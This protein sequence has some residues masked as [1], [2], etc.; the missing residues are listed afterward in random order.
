MKAIHPSVECA[1]ESQERLKSRVKRCCVGSSGE[2]LPWYSP[3]V[4]ANINPN[5]NVRIKAPKEGI[6][7]AFLGSRGYPTLWCTCHD[8]SRRRIACI[9]PSRSRGG[10]RHMCN[11]AHCS[12]NR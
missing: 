7:L 8:M 2:T 11:G 4:S 10:E 5:F 3:H 6:L 1:N 12:L 9:C